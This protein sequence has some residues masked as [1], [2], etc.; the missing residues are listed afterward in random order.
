MSR[1]HPKRPFLARL[2]A[3]QELLLNAQA[4]PGEYQFLVTAK[5]KLAMGAAGRSGRTSI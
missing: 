3:G 5:D 4:L 1:R 2:Q